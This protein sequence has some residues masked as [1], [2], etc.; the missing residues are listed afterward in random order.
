MPDS[1]DEVV[2]AVERAQ[3]I[4]AEHIEPGPRDCNNTVNDLLEVLD[5]GAL[6]EAVDEVKY[7]RRFKEEGSAGPQ[8]DRDARRS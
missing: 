1:Q 5:D 3:R 4:L 6:V 2:I 7:E 8:Q